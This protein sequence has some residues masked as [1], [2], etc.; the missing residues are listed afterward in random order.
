MARITHKQGK[1]SECPSEVA[2]GRSSSDAA[3]SCCTRNESEQKKTGEEMKPHA[4]RLQPQQFGEWARKGK[5]AT[6]A[7]NKSK[8]QI[9]SNGPRT[10]NVQQDPPV[11]PTDLPWR[12]PGISSLLLCWHSFFSSPG[13]GGDAAAGTKERTEKGENE[14]ENRIKN[15]KGEEKAERE[16]E[17]ERE[18]VM[19]PFAGGSRN[20]SCR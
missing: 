2:P 8:W 16:R 6:N 13:G 5:R 3:A 7:T 9:C 15:L 12:I 10:E 1:E 18:T 4:A 19:Y 17:R 11:N 14:R 20:T